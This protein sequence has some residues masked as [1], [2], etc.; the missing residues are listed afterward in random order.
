MISVTTT[1]QSDMA[2]DA[3]IGGHHVVMDAA[4]EFGGKE[5]G[6]RPKPLLLA[7]LGGCTGMDVVSLLKKMRVEYRAFRILATGETSDEH[8][9]VFTKIH[10]IYEFEGRE[11]PLDK[12]KKAIDLSQERYC[13]VSAMLKEASELTYEVRTVD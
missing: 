10:L 13:S 11:L 8:P 9:K 4:A 12:L 5:S 2:F 7:A 1:W 6:P 3:Q